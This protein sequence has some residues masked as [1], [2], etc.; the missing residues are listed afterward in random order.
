MATIKLYNTQSRSIEEIIPN[1]LDGVLRIYCCGPTVYNYAHIGNFRTFLLQDVLRRLLLA[2][3]YE[4]RFVR[5]LTD[6]DDKTIRGAR[7][8]NIS[9]E[10]FT[11]KWINIFRNDCEELNI[12]APDVEPKAASHIAEQ[13]AMIEQLIRKQYAYMTSD[14]SVYFRLSSFPRYG[15]LSGINV[16]QLA[17]QNENSAGQT[18]LADEYDRD[19]VHDFA[20]WKAYK[21]EDGGIFW[22]SPWGKGRPG[23]HIECS[24]MSVKYLGETID[25]HGGG[26]DLC[27]P[28]HENEIAQTECVT[29]K[30]FVGH[31]FHS[32][33]L[34]IEGQKM[35]KS[36]GNLF[37]LADLKSKG[38]GVEAIRYTLIS[39]YYRQALNFTFS[40]LDAAQSALHKLKTKVRNFLEEDNLFLAQI[41][42][43][44][45]KVNTYH[46]FSAAIEALKNDL[47]TP[48][49]LGEMFSILNR[50]VRGER[51][52]WEE[53]YMLCFILGI[54]RFIFCEKQEVGSSEIPSDIVELG[55]E[56]W[57]AKQDKNFAESDRLRNLLI[58][59]G[60]RII[61][62]KDG[63]RLEKK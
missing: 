30:P 57:R 7:G 3:G 47:N 38:Y 26:I 39:G 9:L 51:Q 23:W 59:R 15:Q 22:E 55:V 40:G 11:E 20:L 16:E 61:D 54:E 45:S 1:H 35:S 46:Y 28:H 8:E 5:N 53:L 43:S 4:V 31:W 17:T 32:E 18:N 48:K 29:G 25:I 19:N 36:L 21:E 58:G 24:A 27:F 42:E 50:T 10:Q 52:F 60:W 6:V 63:Y 12:L 33:H 37:T 62:T 13:I 14:G 49:C 41:V 56:R 44:I 2:M 34:Q